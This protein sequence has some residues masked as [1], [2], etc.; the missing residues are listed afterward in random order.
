MAAQFYNFLTGVGYHHP[1][2]PAL[3]HL[4]VGLTIASFIFAI[5]GYIFKGS[6]FGHTAK[7]CTALA[8]LAA[9]PTLIVGYFDWQHF[10]GGA[11]LF[12]IKMKLALAMILIGLLIASIFTTIKHK[13]PSTTLLLIHLFALLVVAGI[14]FFGGA[15][16]YG[17]KSPPVTIAEI[18]SA[19]S[20][21]I[22]A[23]A[24]LFEQSCSFC[25]FTNS[26]DVKVGPGLKDF[27]AKEKMP[28]SGWAMTDANLRK[29]LLTPF[30]Q[31]PPFPQLTNQEIEALTEYLKSL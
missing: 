12:P 30:S 3:T 11:F 28:V 9:I 7:H 15:L 17:K 14:G 6:S 1:L 20:E 25:H 8:L 13:T 2:H 5:L 16:V 4:P 27:F 10:Y 18:D 26:T 29:Q 19:K 22:A 24:K 23:G 21:S 31:M